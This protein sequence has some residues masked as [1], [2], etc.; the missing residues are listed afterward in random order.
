MKKVSEAIILKNDH[1]YEEKCNFHFFKNINKKK[2]KKYIYIIA[3]DT[4]FIFY[5]LKK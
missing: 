2:D 1:F 4:F 3:S 5:F